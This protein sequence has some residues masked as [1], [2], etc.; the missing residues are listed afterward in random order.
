MNYCK[1]GKSYIVLAA[2]VVALMACGGGS[3]KG[4]ATYVDAEGNAVS[5]ASESSNI[6]EGLLFSGD[7]ALE[8]GYDE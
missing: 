2:C 3:G 5:D 6:V 8:K 1:A 7:D 4:S